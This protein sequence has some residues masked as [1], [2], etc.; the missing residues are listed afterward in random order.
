ML[1]KDFLK[2]AIAVCGV[3]LIMSLLGILFRTY[4]S[5]R[6]G[7]EVMGLLQLV[8]SVYYPACTLASSGIYVASTRLCAEA[9]A[10]K[11]RDVNRVLVNCLI[12]GL[13]FGIAAF[14]LLFFGAGVLAKSWL[15]FP[16][17]EGPIQILAF[18]LPFLSISNGLQGFFLSLR[19]ASYSTVLQVTEDFSKIG[20]T[21]ILFAVFAGKGPQG[22]LNSLAAGMAVGE[23]VS[24]IIGYFLC[25]L[26][27]K[28]Y[29][30]NNE[31]KKQKL[32]AEV[33]RIALPC[34]LGGY[35]RSG[36]GMVENILVPRGLEASGL[37]AEQT[38]GA[39]G[40]LEGMA[41]PVL[42]FPATFLTVV[43]KLLVPEIT[44]ENAIGHKE[45][46]RKTATEILRLTAGYGIFVGIFALFFGKNLGMTLYGDR[47]CGRYIALL[48]PL[49]PILYT[50]RVTDGIMKGYNQQV[51]TVK[52]N[53]FEAIFQ[54][55]GVWLL[56]PRTGIAGYIGLFAVGSSV[57]FFVSYRCLKK[58]CGLKFPLEKG[59]FQPLLGALAAILPLKILSVFFHLSPFLWLAGAIPLFLIF[60]RL[61]GEN[62]R[63]KRVILPVL[64][65]R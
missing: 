56:L 13:C 15:R 7:S 54:T 28:D 11:D 38:L 14:L 35:L 53:L 58:T 25:R 6:V 3:S 17:A 57:N 36:I 1:Q 42:V 65:G 29:R 21:V 27:I 45:S 2:N 4:A 62:P 50:D 44:A 40:K 31:T 20:A 64:C 48:G 59:I 34:A 49:V 61:L 23:I 60:Y 41:L 26:K 30:I 46:T 9:M 5:N 22:A 37:T 63:K 12:Y 39:M 43:S 18:G 32:M 51:T 24:C 19:K 52:I 55:L 33:I 10:K 8:L 16:Q 47:V